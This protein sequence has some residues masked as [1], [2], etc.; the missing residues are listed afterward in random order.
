MKTLYVS[1]LDETL[2]RSDERLSDFTVQTINALIDRGM[3]FSYA[4]ARSALTAREVTRGLSPRLPVITYN[5][6]FIVEQ[7]SQNRLH[8]VVFSNT[9]TEQILNVLL[10][11]GLSPFVRSLT[12]EHE[13]VRYQ[14]DCVTSAMQKYLNRRIGDRRLT[15]IQSSRELLAGEVFCFTCMD[16]KERLLPALA[17]LEDHFRCLFFR[18]N[19]TGE[20]WLEVQPTAATKATAVLELKERLGCSRVICFGNGENDIS[21]FRVANECYAVENAHPSLKQISTGII[22]SCD[23]DGV[24]KWLLTHYSS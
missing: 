22:P 5:G 9:D 14:A 20:W 18:D 15:P 19:Y 17:A 11:H 2:L 16:D 10:A 3:I 21:M 13:R 6:T 1:D 8:S 24:A 4:T 12:D 7:G 23:E